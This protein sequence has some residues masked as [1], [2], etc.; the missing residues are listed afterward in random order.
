MK[1]AEQKTWAVEAARSR[2]EYARHQAAELVEQA[3]EILWS[4][5]REYG[6]AVSLV[7]EAAR[8]RRG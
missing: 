5:E 1:D 8:L 3:R 4:C 2:A 6:F 7:A